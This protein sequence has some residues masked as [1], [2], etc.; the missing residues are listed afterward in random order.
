VYEEM[1][2]WTEDISKAR[3]IKELPRNTKRYI[4]RLEELAGTKLVLVSVGAGREE[5]IILKNPFAK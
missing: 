4:K 2:G 5:T 1:A 3:H